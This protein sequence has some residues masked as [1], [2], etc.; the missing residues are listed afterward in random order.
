[1]HPLFLNWDSDHLPPNMDF[2]YYNKIVQEE[3]AALDM[4][5]PSDLMFHTIFLGKDTDGPSIF[6]MPGSLLGYMDCFYHAETKWTS[7][8]DLQKDIDQNA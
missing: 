3:I 5:D 1:M 7:L 4:D 2:A 8:S 6:V